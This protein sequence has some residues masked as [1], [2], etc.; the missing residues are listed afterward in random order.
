[1]MTNRKS[2]LRTSYLIPHTSYLKR[3]TLIE[4]LVVIAIIAVLAGMLL[5][6]LSKA[7]SVALSTS[8]KN[9]MRQFGISA[10]LY[11]SDNNDYLVPMN[12]YKFNFWWTSVAAKKFNY[13]GDPKALICPAQEKT[14]SFDGYSIKTNYAYNLYIGEQ[15]YVDNYNYSFVRNSQIDK[16]T[17]FLTLTD[18]RMWRT[19]AERY[20]FAGMRYPDG[21]K[22]GGKLTYYGYNYEDAVKC[23][24]TTHDPRKVN[25]LYLSGNA[26]SV[27]I[28]ANTTAGNGSPV[29][30]P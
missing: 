16:P 13:L 29:W 19:D 26:D 3:F 2:A 6:S 4:L 20:R 18:G 24:P 25:V 7:K 17:R 5:P 8:C 30:M 1:M 23:F 28:T 21:L 11:S 10:N 12:G 15:G 22:N 9:N 14:A 27:A